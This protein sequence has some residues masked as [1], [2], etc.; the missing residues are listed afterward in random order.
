MLIVSSLDTKVVIG[1]VL[2][3]CRPDGGWSLK[4]IRCDIVWFVCLVNRSTIV[5]SLLWEDI[6]MQERWRKS[7]V[8]SSV[9]ELPT[10]FLAWDLGFR[11]RF[12]LLVELSINHCEYTWVSSISLGNAYWEQGKH[13]WGSRTG[14]RCEGNIYVWRTFNCPLFETS[15]SRSK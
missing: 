11:C 8:R 9:P 10:S 15:T 7:R 1:H 13:D 12:P 2:T 14:M 3:E 5:P 6:I 4:H